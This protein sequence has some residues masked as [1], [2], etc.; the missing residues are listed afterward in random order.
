MGYPE[1]ALR[2]VWQYSPRRVWID[3]TWGPESASDY[4]H[5]A[6]EKA[7]PQQPPVLKV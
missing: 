4:H 5:Q 1:F 7:V 3:P 6:R 2:Y